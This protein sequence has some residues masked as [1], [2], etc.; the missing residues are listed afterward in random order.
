MDIGA[1]WSAAVAGTATIQVLQYLIL[2][3]GLAGSLYTAWRIADRKKVT[4]NRPRA[5]F[6][7]YAV[8]I[9][10]FFAINVVLF[11]LPM[12]HRM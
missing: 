11:A 6:A 2:T 9:A 3:L 10:V 12:A 8:L 4:G 5:Q 1:Q 7:P